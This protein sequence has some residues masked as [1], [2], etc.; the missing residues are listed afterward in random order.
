MFDGDDVSGDV[1]EFP[2]FD[3]VLNEC[4]QSR[5]ATI[6]LL[7]TLTEADLDLPSVQC[8]QGAENLFGT[9]RRCFQYAGNHWFMHRG[10]FADARR[11]AGVQR[12]WY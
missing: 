8:P 3:S 7:D 4:R 1:S 2:P 12:M 9:T 11:A 10:Q 6:A 5:A